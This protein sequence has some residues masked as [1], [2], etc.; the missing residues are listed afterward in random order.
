MKSKYKRRILDLQVLKPFQVWFP[1]KFVPIEDQKKLSSLRA[2][3]PAFLK[4][5]KDM[6]TYMNADTTRGEDAQEF[7]LLCCNQT[8]TNASSDISLDLINEFA[9]MELA[10]NNHTIMMNHKLLLQ[11]SL[12]LK[13]LDL[14]LY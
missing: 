9:K 3:L 5:I 13:S 1:L 8:R 6:I 11:I 7:R 12:R 2:Q 4:T 14:W 10:S